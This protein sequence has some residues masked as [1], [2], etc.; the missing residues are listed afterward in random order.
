MSRAEP[1]TVSTRG[2]PAHPK[3]QIFEGVRIEAPP[4]P[5]QAEQMD[6]SRAADGIDYTGLLD[7]YEESEVR[8][9]ITDFVRAILPGSKV[10]SLF[11][12]SGPDAM[13]LVHVWF[14]ADMEV[15]R[16]AHPADGDCL[17]YVLAGELTMG[18]RVLRAGDG[19]LVPNGSPYTYRAGPDGVEVLEFRAGGGVK[20]APGFELHETSVESLRRIATSARANQ[21]RWQAPDRPSAASLSH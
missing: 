1:E 10:T 6:V 2:R 8:D 16:H 11:K 4:T 9:A 15:V 14:G 21:D 12:G 3:L 13:S 18:S 19:F 5:Q 17:Y 20:G 7:K